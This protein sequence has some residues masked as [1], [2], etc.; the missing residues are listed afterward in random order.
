MDC[1]AALLSTVDCCATFRQH[2]CLSGVA[3]IVFLV[4]LKPSSVAQDAF[5][6]LGIGRVIAVS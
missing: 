4:R 5:H 3:A 6:L 2:K 1:G